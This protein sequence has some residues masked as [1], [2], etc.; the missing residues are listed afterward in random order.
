MQLCRSQQVE[1]QVEQR[2]QADPTASP[3]T[4]SRA[5]RAHSRLSWEERLARNAH[6][7]EA[8]RVRI[9]LFG[10]PANFATSLGLPTA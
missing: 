5:Q 8:C 1:V 4:L 7:P 9:K 6:P 2:S 3:A 10:I